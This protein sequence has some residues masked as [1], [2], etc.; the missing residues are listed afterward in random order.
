MAAVSVLSLLGT[1]GG[2]QPLF[3]DAKVAAVGPRWKIDTPR[4]PMF[5]NLRSL[6][7]FS[8]IR[9][10]GLR[11]ASWGNAAELTELRDVGFVVESARNQYIKVSITRFARGLHQIRAR[12][13]AEFR[14]NENGGAFFSTRLRVTLNVATFR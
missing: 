2:P 13:S 6:L 11:L 7:G 1:E 14:A 12:N 3:G 5:A 9:S 10:L 8:G 4:M